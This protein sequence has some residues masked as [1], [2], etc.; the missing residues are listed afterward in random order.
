MVLTLKEVSQVIQRM[1]EG[2]KHFSGTA[3]RLNQ[4]ALTIQLLTQS[5]RLDSPRIL[6]H[7]VRALGRPDS[8]RQVGHWETVERQLAE[9]VA[10]NPFV[11]VAFLVDAS[12]IMVA[13][14]VNR[15]WAGDAADAE[16]RHR[17]PEPV[18][19][20]VVPGGDPGRP[21]RS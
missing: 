19:P 11:E 1:A 13:F 10:H 15:D 14:S 2:L 20:P 12:G 4:L 17:R 16:P 3:E 18:R 7:L 5:F 8:A 9:L 21:R 6:K